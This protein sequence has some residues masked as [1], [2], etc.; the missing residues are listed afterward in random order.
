[1]LSKAFASWGAGGWEGETY[2]L[3]RCF[4][5]VFSKCF[6][7]DLTMRLCG[8]GGRGTNLT[9]LLHYPLASRLTALLPPIPAAVLVLIELAPLTRG[10]AVSEASKSQWTSLQTYE[11]Q[12]CE[13]PKTN[14]ALK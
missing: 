12:V 6:P 3:L 11:S 14:E 2:V 4:T 8:G 5:F 10:G 9:T 1:M 7:T 13:T